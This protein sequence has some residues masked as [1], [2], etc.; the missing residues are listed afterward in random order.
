MDLHQQG[1]ILGRIVIC[2]FANPVGMTQNVL[3][4]W[5][6][7]FN[8]A[9]GE[10]FNRNFPDLIPLLETQHI[11][12]GPVVPEQKLQ[13]AIAAVPASDTVSA[14]RKALLSEAL[15]HDVILDL[16]CDTAGVLHLYAN[17]AQRERAT[18]LAACMNIQVVFLEHSAGG[19]PFDESCNRPWNW[20]IDQGLSPQEERPFAA[21]IE[22][23]GQADVND[24]LAREDAKGILMFLAS[25]GLLRLDDQPL[26][27]CSPHVYP[28]EGA[29]HLPSP[30]HG[31]LAW[32]KRPGDN[33]SKGELI[34][35]LVPI[36]A[37][38]GTPRTPIHSDVDGV[39]VVQPL[40]KLV[41]A[42]QRV[43]LLAGIEP[44]SN[45]RAGQ[46][47]NHF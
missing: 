14:L 1:R 44:L 21:S 11:E 30:G 34:A 43:A 47:L 36:D 2:P 6:G 13:A 9:N 18:R 4:F 37:L 45:R 26:V 5:T 29:S 17:N 40:F 3:G 7:R 20:L 32:K 25:E 27:K 35:E 24:E 15:Q 10:N 31:L 19:Q 33:V 42:G 41:R 16:H 39:L 38:I 28:L 12:N 22:L 23:R 46:L 8:L